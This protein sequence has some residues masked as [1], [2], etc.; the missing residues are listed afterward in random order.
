VIASVNGEIRYVIAKPLTKERLEAQLDF[1]AASDREDPMLACGQKSH[2]AH[3]LRFRN[4][5][6]LHAAGSR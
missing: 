4:F 3:R 2:E 5:A 6:R 1:A